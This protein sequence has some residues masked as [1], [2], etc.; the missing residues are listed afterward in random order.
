MTYRGSWLLIGANNRRFGKPLRSLDALR[1]KL[2]QGEGATAAASLAEGIIAADIDA[3]DPMIG[4]IIAEA[5]VAWCVRHK[6]PYLV[7]DS[8]RPGG[9]HVIA[10]ITHHRVDPAE[11]RTLCRELA[12]RYQVVVDDRTNKALRLLTAPHRLGLP[13]AVLSCTLTPGHV[14]DARNLYTGTVR[15][16]GT[17]TKAGKGK[18]RIRRKSTAGV[19]DQTRSGREFRVAMVLARRGYTAEEA[20]VELGHQL[21]ETA[22]AFEQGRDWWL[23]YVWLIA[24]TNVAAEQGRTAERAWATVTTQSLDGCGRDWWDGQWELS[25]EE[26]AL[27]RPR[28]KR[29]PGELAPT[30]LEAADPVRD[31]Q[32]RRGLAEAVEATLIGVD[33]RRR[34]S[35]LIMLCALVPALLVRD[36]SMSMRQIAERGHISLS[37]VEIAIAT[38]I[39]YGLLA[40]ARPYPG[41]SKACQSYVL[42]RAALRFVRRAVQISRDTSCSSPAPRPLGRR[43]PAKLATLHAS[44]RADWTPRADLLAS[45]APGERLATSQ[46]PTAKL[47]RSRWAQKRWWASKSAAEQAARLK[48][49]RAE[50]DQLHPTARSGWL[51]W[52]THRADIDAAAERLL[53]VAPEPAPEAAEIL[54]GAPKT[55]HRGLQDFLALPPA[56]RPDDQLVLAAA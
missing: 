8:G 10:A 55:Y 9:R 26:A 35:V 56:P 25:L 24:I 6:L 14:L 33:P 13:S 42:G 21:P 48:V 19:A 45:L 40:V 4:D 11:W 47:L 7:R 30:A 12:G 49:R 51:S 53:A 3:E 46:H 52:L 38:A 17:K 29:L 39:K 43:C 18:D 50:L 34:R 32:M 1:C 22:K 20:W 23:R 27:D 15:K 16:D 44:Q 36:G 2:A 31:E 54:A 5:F 41:G 37:T 28:A